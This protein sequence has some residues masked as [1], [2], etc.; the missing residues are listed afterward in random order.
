MHP[1]RA[2]AA[3]AADRQAA[4][5]GAVAAEAGDSRRRVRARHGLFPLGVAFATL[6]LAVA[7]WQPLYGVFLKARLDREVARIKQ[8]YW[9]EDIFPALY[10]PEG[11]PLLSDFQEQYERY[12]AALVRACADS[13]A[14]L[15]VLFIPSED[16][17]RTQWRWE[18]TR[19]FIRSLCHKY[20]IAFLD[21]TDEFLKYDPRQVTLLPKDGH[22][23]PFGHRVV[24]RFLAESLRDEIYRS[25]VSLSPPRPRVM[26]DHLPN[27]EGYFDYRRD[28]LPFIINT[29]GQGFRNTFEVTFPKRKQR[30]LV[31]GDSFT[32]GPYVPV[33]ETFPEVLTRLEPQWEWINAGKSGYT[34]SDEAELFSE[35]ARFTEPDIVI[36]Q[37]LDNDLADFFYF[38]RNE[39]ARDN[40]RRGPSAEESKFLRRF[41]AGTAT[42]SP[43]PGSR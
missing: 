38:K 39:F 8:Q 19:D 25:A 26:G 31:L 35:R 29:N 41:N 17:M 1:D 37:V 43:F 11:A 34:I 40:R 12:F 5:E 27:D 21:I 22:L 16:Y 23:S 6:V 9:F 15:K 4:E 18:P 30:I 32:F 7:C 13:G 14:R 10:S 3:G 20:H 36:L 42:G 33:E 28:E 2:Q 24:A